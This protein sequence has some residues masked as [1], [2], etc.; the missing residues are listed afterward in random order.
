M[1][2][3][4]AAVSDTRHNMKILNLG[5]GH[6]VSPH[7]SVVNIDW[8]MYIRVRGNPVLNALAL[9]L[10]D[11]T[12]RDRLRRM[13]ENILPHDLSKGIP[14][15]DGSVDAVFHSNML[16]H[17][18]R[19]V[20]ESFLVECRRV[21]KPGGLHRIV[22]PDFELAARRYLDHA[23]RCETDRRELDGHDEFIAAMLEQSVRR[24]A[25]GTRLQ[26]PL[27]RWLENRLLGD[28]RRRGETHQWAYDRF[29]LESKLKRAGYGEVVV[30]DFR[31][32]GIAGWADYGLDT[33]PD[34]TEYAPGSLYIEARA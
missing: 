14:F 12:R 29:T 27:R 32:S 1:P 28:A 9:A 31:C 6:K 21:L 3:Q 16:E 25:A 13:P 23:A 30:H 11:S 33:N 10:L 8:S 7:P 15:G 24:E 34:G 19:E 26:P 17:L 18:D 22:V 5:C 2:R 4:G 20:A